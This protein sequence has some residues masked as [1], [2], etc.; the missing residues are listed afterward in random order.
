ALATEPKILFLDEP[1]AGMNPNE[2]ANLT[3]L[4]RQIQKD[5]DITV[6]LIE[7]DMSLVMNVCERIYVLEY[8][9]LIAH[10]TPSEIQSNP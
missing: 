6:V 3:E 1:A 5:F 8:G 2:T 4:I 7:H 10:G 9:K